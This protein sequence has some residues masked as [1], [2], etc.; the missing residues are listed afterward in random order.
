MIINSMGPWPMVTKMPWRPG[1]LIAVHYNMEH[2]R[3]IRLLLLQVRN[4]NLEREFCRR[5]D[6]LSY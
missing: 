1:M 2:P 6:V 5:Y 3:G 4:E